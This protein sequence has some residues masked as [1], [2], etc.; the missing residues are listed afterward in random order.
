[1]LGLGGVA[2]VVLASCGSDYRYVN[3]SQE[4]TFFRLPAHVDVFRIRSEQ[5]TDRPVPLDLGGTDP[6]NV[7]FDASPEPTPDHLDDPAPSE[8][9]GQASVVPLSIEQSEG[10]SVKSLRSF[11][12]GGD[13]PL[14]QA[15]SGD[16]IEIV[17]FESINTDGGLSGSRV[18]YNREVA[19]GVWTTFDQSS[20]LDISGRKAYFFEV[21]C[22]SS[23]FKDNRQQISQ[24][25]DSWQVRK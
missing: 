21:K 18:V 8:L 2:A 25:V 9:V 4:G 10:V 3:N 24:I 22:E 1:M 12:A 23:C 20:L 17:A 7:V 15:Q 19:E 6:W 5:P 14:D 11:A 16:G 13:D